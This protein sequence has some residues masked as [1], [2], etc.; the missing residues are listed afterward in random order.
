VKRA[1]AIAGLL[2]V[3]GCASSASSTH[4][5]ASPATANAGTAASSPSASA[6]SS[7]FPAASGVTCPELSWTGLSRVLLAPADFNRRDIVLC[8]AGGAAHPRLLTTLEAEGLTNL[9]FISA[10]RI[11][12]TAVGGASP[13][14]LPGDETTVVQSLS[15]QTGIFTALS[16]QTADTPG[17]PWAIGWSHDGTMVGY[18]TDTGGPSHSFWFSARAPGSGDHRRRSGWD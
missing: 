5:A 1:L 6:V 4:P 14:A 16:G 11:G 12:L 3:S 9:Q 15:L 18:I 8:D 17:V 2:V 10:D 13:T 7:P